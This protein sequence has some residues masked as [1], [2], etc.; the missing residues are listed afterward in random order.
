M[1]TD[2]SAPTDPAPER[3]SRRQRVLAGLLVA[4]FAAAAILTTALSLGT[5]CLTTDGADTRALAE[6]IR[7]LFP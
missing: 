3:Y 1:S 6:S 5:Y 2:A 7:S 4:V